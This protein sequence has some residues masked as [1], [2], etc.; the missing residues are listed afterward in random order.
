MSIALFKFSNMFLLLWWCCLSLHCVG[1]SAHTQ[2]VSSWK[3][4]LGL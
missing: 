2:V 1:A 3:V 4:H